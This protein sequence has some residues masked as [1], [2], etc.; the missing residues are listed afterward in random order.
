MSRL[1][2]LPDP[3]RQRSKLRALAAGQTLFRRGDRATAIFEIE[4]G[5][6]RLFRHTVDDREIILHTARPGDV[7][8]EAA[9]FSNAYKCDAVAEI[10][11]TVRAY[12]KREL[13]AAF[14]DDP[15]LG[16]HFMAALAHQ[17][18]ALRARL[19]ERNIRSARERVM[20]HLALAAGED[21]R[22]VS[23]DGTLMHL[24]SEIGLTHEALYRT[25]TSLEKAGLITRAGSRI[26]LGKR[27]G[28]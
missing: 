1:G 9:L 17:V 21:G 13:L 15:T 5:R 14:R 25:L 4:Q 24:A 16:E 8:A 22:T 12:S 19:E 7:F 2:W 3:I 10:D 20:H 28:V 23:L 18:H 6:L 27:K 26:V 11:S